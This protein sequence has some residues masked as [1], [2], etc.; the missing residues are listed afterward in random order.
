MEAHKCLG[1]DKLDSATESIP[2]DKI[3]DYEAACQKNAL[4]GVRVAVCI[5][6]ILFLLSWQTK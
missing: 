5:R 6:D 3:P 2:S 4:N 1:K